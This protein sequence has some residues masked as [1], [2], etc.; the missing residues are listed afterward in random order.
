MGIA[1]GTVD[2]KRWAELDEWWQRE[3]NRRMPYFRSR[4]FRTYLALMRDGL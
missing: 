1:G 3:T 2:P 4:G